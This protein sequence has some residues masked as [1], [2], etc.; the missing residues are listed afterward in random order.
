MKKQKLVAVYKIINIVTNKLYIGQ[1]INPKKRF[2]DHFQE[3]RRGHIRLREAIDEY[4]REAFRM[5][6]VCWCATRELAQDMEQL[7]IRT[8][9]TQNNGY[10][11]APGVHWVRAGEDNPFY[12]KRH[13]QEAI[14]KSR[15][16]RGEYTHSAETRLKIANG[17]RGKIVSEATKE[18]LRNRSISKL[19]S[20]RTAESNRNRVWTEE[21]KAKLRLVNTGKKMPE[22]TKA[23]I[24]ES[25]KNRVWTDESRAKISAAAKLR[26]AKK[27][28]AG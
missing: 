9:D 25:N 16:S 17:N 21:S 19:C 8:W 2:N 14:A 26:H 23:K 13:T 5:E 15:A 4:G 28:E 7:L 12:G 22:N 10:N 3:A 11:V 1:T 20:E 6:I 18:K 27:Q 24:I